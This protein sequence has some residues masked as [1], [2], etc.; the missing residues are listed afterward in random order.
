MNVMQCLRIFG[1]IGV[2]D[3]ADRGEMTH[4]EA[5]GEL[6]T[7]LVM[8][9]AEEVRE[10]K[11][12]LTEAGRLVYERLFAKKED[13]QVELRFADDGAGC[14]GVAVLEGLR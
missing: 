5:F 12:D 8:R 3:I 10:G 11:F 14:V 4:K 9:L 6:G 2:H 7:M 13:D 1:P